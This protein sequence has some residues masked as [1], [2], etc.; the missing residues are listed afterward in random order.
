MTGF[1]SKVV[2]TPLVSDGQGGFLCRGQNGLQNLPTVLLKAALPLQETGDKE[3]LATRVLLPLLPSGK[4]P[5]LLSQE[6][7]NWGTA[8]SLVES[9]LP[10]TLLLSIFDSLFE[11]KISCKFL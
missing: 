8:Q 11:I 3:A 7:P 9:G 5:W 2:C 10:H 1:L 4:Q 6:E